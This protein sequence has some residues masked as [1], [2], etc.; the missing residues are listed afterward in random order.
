[1]VHAAPQSMKL[2][3]SIALSGPMTASFR[4]NRK[5]QSAALRRLGSTDAAK[6]PRMRLR[7]AGTLAMLVA[8]AVLSAAC[9]GTDTT[10]TVIAA[11]PE[12]TGTQQHDAGAGQPGG[13]P[14]HHKPV[15]PA[16]AEQ[17][18]TE[19][20]QTEQPSA[21]PS[22]TEQTTS[23]DDTVSAVND[24]T[25][26]PGG[27]Q[28]HGADDQPAASPNGPTS[29][30][31]QDGERGHARID[32]VQKVVRESWP[33]Q[34]AV[35]V[36]GSMRDGCQDLGWEMTP[37]GITYHVTVWQIVPAAQSDWACTMAEVP[38]EVQIELGTSETENFA[39][40][41]NGSPY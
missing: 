22:T 8:G 28:D 41:V 18:R 10:S 29:Y 24:G 3:G 21:A 33:L 2:S 12:T 32:S 23:P 39:V 34:L 25:Q 7:P 36:N 30:G 16:H 35:I 27:S 5:P 40:I 6:Q 1:M 20:P 26:A 11:A 17:P 37:D 9:G 15:I 4:N 38:F 13:D 14:A 31:M 19:Q